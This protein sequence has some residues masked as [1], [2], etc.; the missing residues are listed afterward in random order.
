[1]LNK[2]IIN[3]GGAGAACST[4]TTQILDAGAT[5]SLALYRFEDNAF[6]TSNSTGY[7]NKGALFNGSNS[8]IS[9]TAGSFTY[10]GEFS[11]TAWIKLS[12]SQSSHIILENYE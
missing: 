3:T 5:E 9:L 10:T 8:K 12:S 4:D 6:D 2:R 1:M 11:I 7:I